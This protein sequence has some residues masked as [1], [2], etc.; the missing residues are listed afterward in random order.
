M[1]VN[2]SNFHI[3]GYLIN[4]MLIILLT[5]LVLSYNMYVFFPETNLK[6]KIYAGVVYWFLF[7]RINW[8]K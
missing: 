8:Q 1:M 5:L 3:I 7:C 2:F 4:N 6:D